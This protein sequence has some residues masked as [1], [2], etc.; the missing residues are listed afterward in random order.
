MEIDYKREFIKR[1]GEVLETN[2][3]TMSEKGIEFTFLMNCLLG[4]IVIIHEKEK[5]KEK[6]KS[7]MGINSFLNRQLNDTDLLEIINRQPENM[8][9]Y[10]EKTIFEFL[11]QL[12]NGI[13]HQNIEAINVTNEKESTWEAV[14][15]WNRT[16]QNQKD[17]VTF[18]KDNLK[19]FAL[20]LVAKY[21]EAE[22]EAEANDNA[23][24]TT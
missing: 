6:Q 20:E 16:S 5:E 8:N 14:K 7:R 4:T 19:E 1:T 15:I 21:L 10:S 13:A 17:F 18:T 22:E 12:R 3:T 2:F 11:K 23:T 24:R 9:L